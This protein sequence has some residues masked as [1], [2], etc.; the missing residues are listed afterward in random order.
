MTAGWT[1]CAWAIFSRIALLDQHVAVEPT[2]LGDREH[3]DAAEGTRL[4]RQDLALGHIG[5]KRAL[6]V[7]LQSVEGDGAGCDVAL[8]CAACNVRR[9]AVFQQPVLDK[10]V[11]YGPV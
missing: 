10:L 2:H 7:A 3:R 5:A 1:P 6:G 11:F 9:P 4:D 8:E